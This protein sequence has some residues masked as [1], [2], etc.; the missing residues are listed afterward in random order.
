MSYNLLKFYI[1][2]WSNINDINE[3]SN[4]HDMVNLRQYVLFF[5]RKKSLKTAICLVFLSIFIEYIFC[6]SEIIFVATFLY[7]VKISHDKNFI[8]EIN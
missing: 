4:G 6:K 5:A 3:I 7:S 1:R 2:S 8:I